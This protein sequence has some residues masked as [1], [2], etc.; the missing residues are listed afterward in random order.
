M[1]YFG[2]ILTILYTFI[3]FWSLKTSTLKFLAEYNE[4]PTYYRNWISYNWQN[5][6][7]YLVFISAIEIWSCRE[8]RNC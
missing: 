4:L 5:Y 2:F 3:Q 1:Y 7:E 8:A 6:L